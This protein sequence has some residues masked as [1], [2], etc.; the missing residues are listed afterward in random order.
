MWIVLSNTGAGTQ[1]AVDA[2]RIKWS[3]IF[4]MMSPPLLQRMA[5]SSLNPASVGSPHIF[6]NQ[7]GVRGL[8]LLQSRTRIEL[9]VFGLNIRLFGMM[10]C[11]ST[12]KLCFFH[13]GR[14]CVSILNTQIN[15]WP[16]ADVAL[17]RSLKRSPFG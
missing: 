3:E 17:G 11:W 13:S 14:A 9:S 8:P 12:V 2:V 5:C 4:L 16:C 7:I 10:T 6:G 1:L 15:R